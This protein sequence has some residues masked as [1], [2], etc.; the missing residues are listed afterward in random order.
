M[1][2]G[3]KFP[4]LRVRDSASPRTSSSAQLLGHFLAMAPAQLSTLTTMLVQEVMMITMMMLATAIQFQVTHSPSSCQH[5]QHQLQ[6]Q[7]P[8]P[9]TIHQH[10]VWCHVQVKIYN[11]QHNL[12]V[13]T[14]YVSLCHSECY[15]DNNDQTKI[16]IVLIPTKPNNTHV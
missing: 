5:Q 16:Q 9:L 15:N 2:M 13:I 8:H 3:W 11:W 6:Y 12:P 4:D 1:G 14:I 10:Q 7:L